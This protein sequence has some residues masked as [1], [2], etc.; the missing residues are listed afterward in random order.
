MR[1]V[2]RYTTH[3][4]I[5][6]LHATYRASPPVREEISVLKC[7]N[8]AQVF[9]LLPDLPGEGPFHVIECVHRRHDIN[10][11]RSLDSKIEEACVL[12]T[13]HSWLAIHDRPFRASSGDAIFMNTFEIKMGW[14]DIHVGGVLVVLRRRA[15]GE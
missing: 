4:V 11:Y 9:L 5:K 13:E 14:L 12:P 7:I 6:R 2:E 8:Q 15:W 1:L 3:D 10:A